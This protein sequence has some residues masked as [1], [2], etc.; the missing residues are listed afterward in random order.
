[1][2][3]TIGAVLLVLFPGFL[4]AQ[5]QVVAR[6]AVLNHVTVINPTGAPPQGDMAVVITGN[7][8]TAIGRAGGVRVP[9]GA[10][11]IEASGKFVIPGLA[12]MHHHLE[13]GFSLPGPPAPG[14]E[15]PSDVWKRNLAQMLGW[16]FTTIFSTGMELKDFT[17]LRDAA[18]DDAAALPRFFGVGRAI[19]VKG[20]HASEPNF[21]SYLPDA[22]DE[23]RA[24]V[25]DLKLAGADTIKFIYDDRARGGRPPVPVMKAEVMQAIIAEAHIQGLRAYVHAPNLH[26]AKDALRAGA[27]GLVH[28]VVNAPVDDEFIGLMK[29]NRAVYITTH[30]LFNAFADVAA[31][32][33]RLEALDERGVVPKD[34]YERFKSPEGVKRYYSVYGVVT[35]DQLQFLANNAR[36]VFDAGILVVAGTDT[37]VSGVLLGPSSQMELVLLVESGLTTT[38]ALRTATLNAATMLGREKDLGTVETA[39][40]ADLVVLDANPLA[41]IRNIRKVHRVIKGGVIYD[42]AQVLAGN[43]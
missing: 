21:G 37:T 6:S 28:A 32:V 16:G 4:A 19:T 23:A 1:M 31:W 7:R 13:S 2:T 34:V 33:R 3:R 26:Q 5:Q 8:I 12:D 11:I 42:P 29:K 18:S 38:E 20:G 27:D 10:Q 39:K 22:P 43:R 17:R 25:R 9:S 24:Y 40:L 14:R 15:A 41:D 35:K 30:S 36:R